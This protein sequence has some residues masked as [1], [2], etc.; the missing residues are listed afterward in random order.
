LGR[1]IRIDTS[2]D[3]PP[4]TAVSS[5]WTSGLSISPD[6]T[7]STVF[8]P[9]TGPRSNRYGGS[10]VA[11]AHSLAAGWST[12]VVVEDVIGFSFHQAFRLALE[13]PA[14]S[15][16]RHRRPSSLPGRRPVFQ[17]ETL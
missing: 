14:S 4:G 6:W 8:R 12:T 3:G 5:T 17:P 1:R 2:P 15:Q 10:A 9:S 13:G 16:S 11:A 7:S